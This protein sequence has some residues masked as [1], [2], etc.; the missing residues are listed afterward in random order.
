MHYLCIMK[1]ESYKQKMRRLVDERKAK[2]TIKNSITKEVENTLNKLLMDEL[3]Y[4]YSVIHFDGQ[5]IRRIHPLSDKIKVIIHDT[6]NEDSQITIEELTLDQIKERYKVS[7]LL[8]QTKDKE[9]LIQFIKDERL[10]RKYN[11]TETGY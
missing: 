10:K 1:S 7:G 2:N 8:A 6:G 4:G 3:I 9:A 5:D 11:T